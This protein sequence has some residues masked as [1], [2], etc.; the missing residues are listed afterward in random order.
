MSFQTWQWNN[1]RYS[2]VQY[3]IEDEGELKI[4]RFECEYRAVLRSELT[5][6]LLSNG[7]REVEWKFPCETGFY[8]P[9]VVA[10]K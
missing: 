8:Q 3:I 4:S 1:E 10:K 5:D 7:F 9:I 6:L 2:L